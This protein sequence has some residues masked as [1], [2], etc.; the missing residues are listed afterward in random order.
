MKILILVVAILGTAISHEFFAENNLICGLCTQS[1]KFIANEKFESLKLFLEPFPKAQHL[2]SDRMTHLKTMAFE[3]RKGEDICAENGMCAI[4]FEDYII[5]HAKIIEEVNSAEDSSWFAAPNQRFMKTKASD[6]RKTLGTIV[7]FD[8]MVDLPSRDD[9]LDFEAP[10]NFDSRTNW[11]S[12]P[13]IG[14]VRD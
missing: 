4:N 3:G 8:W 9:I 7:D 14:K 11:D 5:D 6:V 2:Y 10:A 13:E 12:C 1:M